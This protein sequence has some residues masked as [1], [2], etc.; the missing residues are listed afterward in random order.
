MSAALWA[1]GLL[2]VTVLG[3]LSLAVLW[4]LYLAV[5]ALQRTRDAGQLAPFA[6]RA[7]QMLLYFG[8]V[9]DVLC[10]L[11]IVSIM[12]CEVPRE[13]TVSERLRRLV[14]GPDGWRR[15]LATWYAVVLLNPFSPNGP[16]IPV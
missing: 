2:L 3:I 8:L 9:W 13:A 11:V 14:R 6:F 1:A 16:H 4:V 7:G 10:N 12:F 15:R 5:M